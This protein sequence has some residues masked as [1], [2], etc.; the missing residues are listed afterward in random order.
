MTWYSDQT[1]GRPNDVEKAKLLKTRDEIEAQI[2]ALK[3][4]PCGVTNSAKNGRIEDLTNLAK[5]M[6]SID[7]KLGRL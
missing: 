5:K 6:T 1:E 7:K 2:V 4:S 3:N